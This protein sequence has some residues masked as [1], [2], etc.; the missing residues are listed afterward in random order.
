MPNFDSIV[1]EDMLP[2]DLFELTH[3]Q[4]CSKKDV[5]QV[6]GTYIISSFGNIDPNNKYKY[7]SGPC[8][9]VGR[10]E[11]DGG[12]SENVKPP[13]VGK[14][15]LIQTTNYKDKIVTEQ[16]DGTYRVC[17]CFGGYRIWYKHANL[18]GAYNRLTLDQKEGRGV[19]L[20]PGVT[21]TILSIME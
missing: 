9:S 19:S 15:K 2:L 10:I 5:S 4:V 11:H 7:P 3:A 14:F 6:K 21:T 8:S 20:F 18:E 13:V 1:V 12:A 16:L 17:G